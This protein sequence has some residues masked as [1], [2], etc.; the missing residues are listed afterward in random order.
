[1]MSIARAAYIVKYLWLFYELVRDILAWN[2]DTTF[3]DDM[4]RYMHVSRE[5]SICSRNCRPS[6]SSSS[7]SSSSSVV[8]AMT[9]TTTMTLLQRLQNIHQLKWRVLSCSVVWRLLFASFSLSHSCSSLCVSTIIKRD[10]FTDCTMS[11][12][13]V[14]TIDVRTTN[15]NIM[16]RLC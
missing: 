1:M 9:M 3:T 13:Q 2:C 5:M 6:D 8:V 15:Q 11:V 12:L 10:S 16:S 14:K 7:S 4:A